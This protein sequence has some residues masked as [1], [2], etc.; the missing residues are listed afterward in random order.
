MLVRTWNL[1]HGNAVPVR[2]S[3]YLDEMI[4]LA[5][6]D[7]PDVLCVQEVPA[8][9]LGRFTVADVAARPTLGPLPSSRGIGRRL[10]AV[11]HGLLRSAFSGQGNA[12]LIAPHLR[13][14]SHT[15]LTLNPR[16]FRAT[17]ARS[18][19]LGAVA[20][21]AWGKERR[22]VQAARLGADDGR[23]YLVANTHCTSFPD[24]RLA[25]AELRRAAWFATSTARPE[26]VVI[27]AGDFNLT[28]AAAVMR[29]L[30]GGE[31]GFSGG[32]PGIDHVL[33]RGAEVG[34]ARRWPTE[35]RRVDGVLLSDHAPVDVEIR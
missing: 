11:N 2:R 9:A 28:A 24:R 14:L 1:F 34:E 30:T 27:L 26:D 3:A 4:R 23:T 7:D 33:V 15:R 31:W 6:A 17:E 22:V 21:L 8:W 12:M 16:R 20:R 29:E 19:E 10:T 25:Q 18:L 13:V 35:R 5:T 32:G